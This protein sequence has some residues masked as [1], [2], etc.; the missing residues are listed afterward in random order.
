[1]D[2]ILAAAAACRIGDGKS[3]RS[4]IR[5]ASGGSRHPLFETAGFDEG[6]LLWIVRR[7]IQDADAGW[8]GLRVALILERGAADPDAVSLTFPAGPLIHELVEEQ[9][10]RTPESTAVVGPNDQLTYR[11]LEAQSNRLAGFLTS[12][13]VGPEVR[14]GVA[15]SRSPLT[16]VSILAVLKAGG[17]FVPFDP[18]YPKDRLEYIAQ[19]AGLALLLTD[20]D[21]PPYGVTSVDLRTES[22][23]I[24]AF[25]PTT[26]PAVRID[27]SNLAYLIYTSGST[28]RPKGV[29][30]THS[31]IANMIQSFLRI[32]GTNGEDRV[33]QCASLNFDACIPE[34]FIPLLCGASL[35][36][37]PAE[38]LLPGEPL[39]ATIASRKI[40]TLI[41]PPSLVALMNP[42]AVPSLKTLVV[43][44]EACSG[45]LVDRWVSNGRRMVDAYGPTEATVCASMG[46][47]AP[48]QG[49]PDIGEAIDNTPVYILDSNQMPVPIGATGE[50]YI[51]G[52]GIARGYWNRPDAT[53]LAFVQDPLVPGA[54][55]YR[56]GD[57]GSMQAN[58][59][60]RFL[61]RADEQVKIRGLRIEPGEIEAVLKRHPDV[62]QALVVVR[63]NQRGVKR[64]VAYVVAA[65]SA[66]DLLDYAKRF[67]PEYMVPAAIVELD[68]FPLSPSGKID[69][70]ALPDP[71][72]H[73][74]GEAPATPLENV[75]AKV[76]RA[77]LGTNEHET[78]RECDFFEAGGESL[79]ASQAAG[80][81]SRELALKIG[82]RAVFEHRTV[83]DLA[84]HLLRMLIETAA[85]DE[86]EKSLLLEKIPLLSI[87]KRSRL[88]QR[89]IERSVDLQR[90]KPIERRAEPGSTPLSFQQ[91]GLWFLDQKDPGNP[92]YNAALCFVL[93]GSLDHS[94]IRGAFD[95]MVE[96]HEILRTVYRVIDG[97]PRQVVLTDAPT[98]VRLLD[99]RKVPA[100]KR[101]AAVEK[102]IR[103]EY[104]K[105]F[106]LSNQVVIRALVVRT[107]DEEH[108]VVI[109]A[110]H[111][112]CDGWTRTLLFH[113][114]SQWYA[115]HANANS[116]FRLDPLKIQYADFAAWQ[117]QYL[118]GKPLEAHLAFWRR[119]LAGSPPHIQLP[120]DLPRPAQQTFDGVHYFFSVPN[121]TADAIAT[122][123]NQQ[124]STLY[125]T[126]L[127]TFGALLHAM[128]GQDSVLIGTPMANRERIETEPLMGYFANTVVVRA[129]LEGEPDFRKLLKR[130]REAALD[131]YSH[132]ETPFGKVVED[133]KL[134]RDPSRNPLFQVNFRLRTVSGEEL[135]MPGL[136]VEHRDVEI[137]T[138]KFDLALELSASANGVNGYFEY[139]QALFLPATIE[140]LCVRY[141][142][143]LTDLAGSPDVPLTKLKSFDE[144]RQE[145]KKAGPGSRPVRRGQRVASAVPVNS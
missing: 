66:K 31:G 10:C 44:G 3:F 25:D 107:A 22:G 4:H 122:L 94:A 65:A 60:I 16:I 6:R 30:V 121:A 144:I 36:V 41:L 112:A 37:A 101:A 136:S 70:S 125:M 141:L 75:V 42:A 118:P 84:Q 7:Q 110:H 126:Y 137:G 145:A 55:I 116:P 133:L 113:E 89:L 97:E 135:S 11:Q 109:V 86:S 119:E 67:L 96:R 20:S 104:R 90:N 93:R 100:E 54:R 15:I 50:I 73:V 8:F 53:A 58:G 29:Q 142:E 39:A 51:G 114:L 33:L 9:A 27:P 72:V 127:A 34:I 130:I 52:A 115:R 68:R 128:S 120:C 21:L 74:H 26:T 62:T 105:P 131:A 76:W 80:M 49:D 77:L 95:S 99:A 56:T 98:C 102:L 124:G 123:A 71:P 59:R 87:D 57:L 143:L 132:Q 139:N 17:A 111:I 88:E 32:L 48:G 108:T 140:K 85:K 28:G 69:R 138:A 46:F 12:L 78:D 35:H 106:D 18:A 13:G 38:Q 81:L 117:R 40:T 92:V 61:G 1:M 83:A 91:L 47:A 5:E 2:V 79:L 134:P 129:R 45:D 19:D 63:E 64:L 23:R 43:A 24:A 103:E 82:V 14:V